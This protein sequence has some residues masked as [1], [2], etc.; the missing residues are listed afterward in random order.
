MTERKSRRTTTCN[1][2]NIRF[3]ASSW[4]WNGS[5]KPGFLWRVIFHFHNCIMWEVGRVLSYIVLYSF[6][7]GRRW[8]KGMAEPGLQPT[9]LW[10]TWAY[11]ERCGKWNSP[12][13]EKAGFQP[14]KQLAEKAIDSIKVLR[15]QSIKQT[16]WQNINTASAKA[17]KSPCH[18]NIKISKWLKM[19]NCDP[20]TRV[21]TRLLRNSGPRLCWFWVIYGDII[22]L[23]ILRN[24]SANLDGCLFKKSPQ[25][26]AWQIVPA[27]FSLRAVSIKAE[28]K[29]MVRSNSFANCT[30]RLFQLLVVP[31]FQ[32]L[33]RFW[34]SPNS[35]FGV[36]SAGT[37]PSSQHFLEDLKLPCFLILNA[38]FQLCKCAH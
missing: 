24:P 26:P 30:F 12:K 5:S 9:S 34:K 25:Q 28:T 36:C 35:S 23:H 20:R 19:I 32:L 31:L 38:S 10:N 7:M 37:L 8:R 29:S 6:T 22:Y 1:S 3:L 33:N 13:Q 14:S 27:E 15:S 18:K 2:K 17:V 11:V 4:K 16:T 21:F